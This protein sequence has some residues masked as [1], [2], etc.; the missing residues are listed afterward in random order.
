MIEIKK[1]KFYAYK[2]SVKSEDEVKKLLEG[3]RAEHKKATHVVHAFICSS[4]HMEKFYDAGE[5]SR[6]AGF[7]ILGLLQKKGITDTLVIVARY[8]G[9][10]KLGAGGLIRAYMKAAGEVL[11]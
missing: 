7:P 11:N 10:V 3:V 5:P 1:S 4:P 8:F 6:T 2:F 9:G